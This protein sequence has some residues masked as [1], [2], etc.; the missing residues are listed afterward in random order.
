MV[1][2]GVIVIWLQFCMGECFQDDSLIQDFEAD[3]PQE[4]RLKILN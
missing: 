4:V 1:S 2:L 3:F